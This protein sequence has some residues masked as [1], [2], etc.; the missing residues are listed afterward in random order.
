M[1]KKPIKCK[2]C[3]SEFHYSYACGLKPKHC[4]HC[5]EIGH[6]RSECVILKRHKLEN[7]AD[8]LNP[9]TGRFNDVK[10]IKKA[11]KYSQKWLYTRRLWMLHN[12][13]NHAGYYEC[14]YCHR[15]IP[16]YEMTL[17]HKE[18]RSRAPELRYELTNLVP[19]CADDNS[20]KGS[21]SH[22][23]Y[24]HECAALPRP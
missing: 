23:D 4:T 3:G 1:A 7:K 20:R 6:A 22:D 15:F 9:K 8:K 19:C 17:D 12:P 21:R 11:G 13:A 5:D 2:Y 16:D 14:H 10:P 18:S 24:P